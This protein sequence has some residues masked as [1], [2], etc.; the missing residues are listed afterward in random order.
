MTVP[1]VPPARAASSGL[2]VLS[3]SDAPRDD[4]GRIDLDRLRAALSPAEVLLSA[5]GTG[6][7]CLLPRT[8]SPDLARVVDDGRRVRVRDVDG[9][10][11]DAGDD[12]FAAIDEVAERHGIT[13]DAPVD[14]GTAAAMLPAC[15][16]GLVGA[17]AYELGRPRRADTAGDRSTQR[18]WLRLAGI[19]VAVDPLRQDALLLVRPRLLAGDP[20]SEVAALRA[21][22]AAAPR[23][24]ATGA[25]PNA[26][27]PRVTSSLPRERHLAAIARALEAIA[28]GDV[29]QVNIT[30]RLSGQWDGDVEA[31][32]AALVTESPASHAALLP[33]IGIA[34]VS[35]ETFL[36]VAG[37]MVTT[38][39]IKGTRPRAGDPVLDAAL[40]DDLATSPKDRAENVMVVDLERNDLGR[41]C[42]PGSVRVEELTRVEAHPTVW[43]LVSTVTGELSDGVGYGGLLAATFP[44]GSITGAPKVAAMRLIEALEPVPRG[45]YC[46]AIGALSPGAASLSVAIRTATLW[47]DGTVDYGAGGG[48]VADSDPAAEVAE[49]LDK[50]VPFLRALG[51][52]AAR[53]RD[54]G[55]IVRPPRAPAPPAPTAVR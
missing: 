27:T 14:A 17:L 52:S 9:R 22:I 36:A 39:P 23:P 15:T 41:V 46:G 2:E 3:L 45:W 53:G 54:A 35:P 38:R 21:R 29:Y 43:H 13:P 47:P 33:E 8:L 49:T 12:P 48:I 30:Q 32:F 31:L 25:R 7:T 4:A 44:C 16:G 18:L 51:A 1:T 20:A 42:R 5:E 19:V 50:A 6:W 40:A 11:H 55:A 10:W 24:A 34:S 28:A 37:R 26:A